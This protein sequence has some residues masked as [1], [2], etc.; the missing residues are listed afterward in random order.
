MVALTLTSGQFGP[1]LL[2]SLLEDGV[3]KVTLGLFLSAYVST[4]IV[5]SGY[6]QTD[7]PQRM[8]D[9]ALV[10]ALSALVAFVGFIHR[11]ATDLQADNIIHQIGGQLQRTLH[12]LVTDVALPGRLLATGRWRCAATALCQLPQPPRGTSKPSTTQVWLLGV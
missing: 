2:R 10:L 1:K 9:V 4:L 8:V 5:L 7:R 6:A 12:D 3:S 11:T